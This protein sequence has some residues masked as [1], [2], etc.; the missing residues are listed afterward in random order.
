MS[1]KWFVPVKCFFGPEAVTKNSGELASFSG[2]KA[3][4]VTGMGGSSYHNGAL[5]DIT[6]VLEQNSIKYSIFNK[7]E[8]NPSIDTV[9]TGA[10][11][12]RADE[13]ELVIGVGGGSPLDA[14]KAIAVLAVNDINDEEF[15]RGSFDHAL[16]IIAI[17]T[18][19][20]TGSEVTPYSV[21]TYP[22][23]ESKKSLANDLIYPIMAFIDPLYTI[24]MSMQM[25]IDT[26]VDAY[27]HA[28]EGYLSP[29]S[30]PLCDILA[31][32][33]L[34]ILGKELRNMRLGK[35]LEI[36][37]RSNI[38]YAALLAGMVIS[39]TST[40][41]PHA[42][43]YS[44]TYFKGIPHGRATGMILPAYMK[45]NLN[46]SSPNTRVKEVLAASGIR[47]INEFTSLIMGLVGKP[48]LC[49][50]SEKRKFIDIALK[51]KNITN[52][53]VVPDR[54]DLEYILYN[55]F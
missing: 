4:I 39:H 24:T 6:K 30:N 26:A 46:C 37:N 18:T 1:F 11:Q 12:A 36:N 20:G 34:G 48:P 49:K 17:P 13:A 42:L 7:V 44:L 22:E 53:I 55:A 21:L 15:F 23:I 14:A 51:A 2:Q 52:N 45:F 47:D 9:K 43:G 10:K 54:S 5:K 19:A 16:P 35:K 50:T 8:T 3:L 27:C 40:S 33:T 38:Q 32:E 41:I 28:V 29:R 25:S 31:Q